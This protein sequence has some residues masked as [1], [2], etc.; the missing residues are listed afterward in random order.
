MPRSTPEPAGA[1]PCDGDLPRLWPP[2]CLCD[3][4]GSAPE[5]QP[6]SGC[7]AR[8]LGEGPRTTVEYGEI[9]QMK[10]KHA[11]TVA[12]VNVMGC[13]TGYHPSG[14]AGGY[15]ETRLNDR[16]YEVEFSGNGYTGS[17]T[18]RNYARRRAAELTLQ[19]GYTHFT[20]LGGGTEVSTSLAYINNQAHLVS[21][22]GSTLRIYMLKDEEAEQVPAAIEAVVL[23]CQW[24]TPAW[25]QK[26][27]RGLAEK[28]E[29]EAARLRGGVPI[30]PESVPP[31]EEPKRGPPVAADAVSPEPGASSVPAT[32]E[33]APA[34]ERV[35]RPNPF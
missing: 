25:C 31:V 34:G 13:A 14:F 12:V 5:G 3:R 6:V 27:R 18:T 16:V 15:S 8:P 30:N 32:S 33:G 9:S 22:P 10:L 1:L 26:M 19:S 24:E 28:R 17:S 11:V 35:V 2:S 20:E 21:K 4:Q 23:F 7:I 29:R